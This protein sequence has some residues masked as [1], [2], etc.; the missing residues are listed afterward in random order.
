MQIKIIYEENETQ[1]PI[2]VA[3][4]IINQVRANEISLASYRH[5][6]AYWDE[7][8]D[9]IKSYTEHRKDVWENG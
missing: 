5:R 3:M 9:H 2:D 7:V 8:A 6:L 4:A 1:E